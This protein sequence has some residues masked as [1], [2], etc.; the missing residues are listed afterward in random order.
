M[1]TRLDRVVAAHRD[2]LEVG[3]RS[4]CRFATEG[5]DD[6]RARQCGRSIEAVRVLGKDC[7]QYADKPVPFAQADRRVA[8]ILEELE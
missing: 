2:R 7:F 6:D 5:A 3:E 8:G 1:A 4:D